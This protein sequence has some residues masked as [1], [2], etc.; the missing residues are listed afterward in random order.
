MSDVVDANIFLRL[1]TQDDPEKSARCRDLFRRAARGEEHLTTSEA[2]VAEVVFVLA[3]PA[4][5]RQPRPGIATRL[6][7]VLVNNGLHIEHKEAILEA[8]NLYGAT[9][10]HFVDCLCVAHAR[11]QERGRVFSYD[12]G[13]DRVPDVERVEP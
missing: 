13:M 2:V 12:R 4:L 5:Y 9:T 10:L 3:S 11:R 6:G 8:L 1:L 7:A